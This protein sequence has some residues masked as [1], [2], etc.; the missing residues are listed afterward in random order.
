MEVIPDLL[1]LAP[2]SVEV[3]ELGLDLEETE[4]DEVVGNSGTMAEPSADNT[5]VKSWDGHSL[6]DWSKLDLPD[7]P[8]ECA[9]IVR[10]W[11]TSGFGVHQIHFNRRSRM[12]VTKLIKM[13]N[14]H[15]SGIRARIFKIW[16][17]SGIDMDSYGRTVAAA[18]ALGI[19]NQM[20]DG[21]SVGELAVVATDIMSRESNVPKVIKIKVERKRKILVFFWIFEERLKTFV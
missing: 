14:S 18:K 17:R 3:A 15:S 12:G 1:D 4:K 9:E 7:D 16:R 13:E 21:S 8:E 5:S 20:E 11:E 19:A 2:G 10:R 6:M